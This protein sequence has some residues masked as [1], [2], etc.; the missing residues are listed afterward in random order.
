MIQHSP[1][2]NKDKAISNTSAQIPNLSDYLN[3]RQY[4]ADFFAYKVKSTKKQLRPYNYAMVSA[5]ANIKS[6]NYF[7]LFTWFC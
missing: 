5:A 3:Y 2:F 7:G 6:P 4:L 1:E